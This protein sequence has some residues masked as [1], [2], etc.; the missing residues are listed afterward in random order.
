[1]IEGVHNHLP[2]YGC[3]LLLLLLLLLLRAIPVP[4]AA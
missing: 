2:L 1:L 3:L 4:I